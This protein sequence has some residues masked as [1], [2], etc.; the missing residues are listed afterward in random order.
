[1]CE[2][3]GNSAPIA[4]KHYLQVTDD[5]YTNAIAGSANPNNAQS[6]ALVAHS[7][8]KVA[9]NPHTAASRTDWHSS[10]QPFYV[11]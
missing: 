7:G 1:M 4:D 5:H 2:W 11:Q 6:D 10:A 9:L 8:E 3:L